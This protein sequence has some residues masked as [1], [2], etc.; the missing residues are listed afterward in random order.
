MVVRP[1]QRIMVFGAFLAVM[2][3]VWL[4]HKSSSVERMTVTPQ[5]ILDLFGTCDNKV[6]GGYPAGN[7]KPA[8]AFVCESNG[9]IWWTAGMTV[10]C[11]GV[12]T[13]ECNRTTDPDFTS[14]TTLHDSDGKPLDAAHLPY[15]VAPFPDKH[16]NFREHGVWLGAPVVVIYQGRMNC[17]ILGDEGTMGEASYA[18]AKSL[19]IDPDPVKGGTYSKMTYITFEHLRVSPV[20]DHTKAVDLCT[21]SL[22]RFTDFMSH[23]R[24]QKW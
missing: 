12:V 15:V 19:G 23:G 17:G 8:T 21:Q 4:E 11:D 20:E 9:V 18:M 16:W 13:N 5:R 1:L 14:D 24:R 6:G 3:T 10:D 7:D 22:A 2:L